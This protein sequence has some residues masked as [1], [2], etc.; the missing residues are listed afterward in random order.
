[1]RFSMRLPETKVLLLVLS[2]PLTAGAQTA[3]VAASAD[4]S[5]ADA[6]ATAEH[7]APAE[8]GLVV[9]GRVGLGFALPAIADKFTD[10]YN[11]GGMGLAELGLGFDP[12]HLALGVS[13]AR[14]PL[15]TGTSA[16][17]LP[18]TMDGDTIT[19]V[20]VD[21]GTLNLLALQIVGRY[22]FPL[23]EL[24]PYVIVGGGVAFALP[25]K[26][27]LSIRT[28]N[29]AGESQT[30]KFEA[31][32]DNTTDPTAMLGFGAY[33]DGGFYDIFAQLH[34]NV[35]FGDEVVPIAVVS[36]GVGL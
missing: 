29:D 9:E 30:N 23:T 15:N 1:M 36:V 12:L 6:T 5:T 34:A 31:D 7:E 4:T 10:T 27:T 2:I 19:G 35:L 33:H 20:S 3:R 22:D 16:N 32:A 17:E 13:Y 25:E 26:A 8:S 14:L 18:P 11:P 24:V 28:Q 21:G